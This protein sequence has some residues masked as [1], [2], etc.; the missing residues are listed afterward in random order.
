M[1]KK[2]V[3][4]DNIEI[5]KEL[6]NCQAEVVEAN[7]KYLRALAD[8]KNLENRI[9]QEREMM[10]T[11]VK[12]DIIERLLPIVDNLEK[13]SVFI[14]DPGLKLVRSTFKKELLALGMK[15][16]ELIGKKF[17]PTIAEVLE[18]IEGVQDDVVVEVSQKA[19]ALDGRVIR[20]G[21]VVVSRKKLSI[22]N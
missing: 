5:E 6:V 18:V 12:R 2:I 13:A 11:V 4:K 10:R 8:Y 3:E 20:H 22:N 21:K 9:N 1:S 16:V 7:G 15:E 14:E 19:Y 17:D